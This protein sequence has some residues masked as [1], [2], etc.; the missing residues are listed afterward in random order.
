MI[1]SPAF[2]VFLYDRGDLDYQRAVA[3]VAQSRAARRIV[4]EALIILAETARR[5]GETTG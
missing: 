2:A 3:V 1:D 5:R 4:R